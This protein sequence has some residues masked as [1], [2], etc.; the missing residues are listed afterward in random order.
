MAMFRWKRPTCGPALK[1]HTSSHHRQHHACRRRAFPA[2]AK[3]AKGNPSPFPLRGVPRGGR[4]NIT[5]NNH[6][7][8]S[9]R[10]PNKS[11]SLLPQISFLSNKS[12]ITLAQSMQ[13]LSK[14]GA[15][16][17]GVDWSIGCNVEIRLQ[18]VMSV[19]SE[20]IK[21][22]CDRLARTFWKIV[23]FSVPLTYSNSF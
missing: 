23:G 1:A 20:W 10:Q 12:E 9:R 17:E 11:R 7:W 15:V 8:D 14:G 18:N 4:G 6:Q 16:S 22:H 3:L 21:K 5:R 19:L 13:V 2:A